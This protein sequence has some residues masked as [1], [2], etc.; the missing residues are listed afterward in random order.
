MTADDGLCQLHDLQED[1][2]FLIQRSSNKVFNDIGKETEFI[3]PLGKLVL[4]KWPQPQK[5]LFK[6]LG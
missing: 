4:V 2:N 6:D 1:W 3:C 5:P